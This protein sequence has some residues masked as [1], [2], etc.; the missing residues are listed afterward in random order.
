MSAP[1]G[2]TQPTRAHRE[3]VKPKAAATDE[4]LPRVTSGYC[5]LREKRVEEIGVVHSFLGF[6]INRLRNG[7]VILSRI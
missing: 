6:S 2:E 5:I 1:S 3:H 7:K 4:S